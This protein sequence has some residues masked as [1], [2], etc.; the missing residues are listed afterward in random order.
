LLT[1]KKK[2]IKQEPFPPDGQL[3]ICRLLDIELPLAAN[4]G[5]QPLLQSNH[6]SEIACK[7]K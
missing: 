1:E 7:L 6:C 5:T 4:K 2:G 3:I